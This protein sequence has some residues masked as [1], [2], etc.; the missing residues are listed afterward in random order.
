MFILI[1]FVFNK[2]YLDDLYPTHFK[3]LGN[4]TTLTI[5]FCADC[6][7]SQS[8]Y[9]PDDPISWFQGQCIGIFHHLEEPM[10]PWWSAQ[11]SSWFISSLF[12]QSAFGNY[13]EVDESC[14]V[15]IS[16]ER[17]CIQ[18]L[19]RWGRLFRQHLKRQR[20]FFPG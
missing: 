4:C 2:M 9:K 15:C 1:N 12:T 7:T 17:R 13:P 6:L 14:Q 18:R 16:W 8:D 10:S 11:L 5:G 20:V 19:Q 3:L